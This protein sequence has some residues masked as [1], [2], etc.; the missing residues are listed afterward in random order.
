MLYEHGSRSKHLIL[1]TKLRINGDRALVESPAQLYIRGKL[2]GIEYDL[3]SHLR[4]FSR[5][6]RTAVG[7][8]LITFDAIYIKDSMVPVNPSEHLRID[9]QKL[10]RMRSSYCL[11]AYTLAASDQ[12]VDP[13]LLGEDRPEAVQAFYREAD[14]TPTQCVYRPCTV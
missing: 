9:G 3:V 10:A 8:R 1:P 4:F 13:D 7:W 14:A 2:D 6:R 5:V 12:E 11:L